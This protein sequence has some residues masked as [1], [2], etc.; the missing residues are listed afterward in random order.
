M[1]ASA[2]HSSI[3][4]S[5]WHFDLYLLGL[6]FLSYDEHAQLS[7]WQLSLRDASYVND[8]TSL[9]DNRIQLFRKV[10]SSRQNKSSFVHVKWNNVNEQLAYIYKCTPSECW[11]STM[12]SFSVPM[13]IKEDSYCWWLVCFNMHTYVPI[14]TFSALHPYGTYTMVWPHNNI[15]AY[16]YSRQINRAQERIK[17]LFTLKVDQPL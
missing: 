8:N 5:T 2:L 14:F 13:F 9:Q 17:A 3:H 6:A 10:K 16:F 1:L 15:A 12:D 7:W 4:S 11:T